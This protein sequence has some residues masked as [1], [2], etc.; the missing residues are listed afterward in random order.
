MKPVLNVVKR[1]HATLKK[2]YVDG[3]YAGEPFKTWGKTTLNLDVEVVLR[4]D[5]GVTVK[6][7][8]ATL[9]TSTPTPEEFNMAVSLA[10]TGGKGFKVVAKRWVVERTFAWL[11]NF[12]RLK[13]DYEERI[14]V[15]YGFRLICYFLPPVKA[16]QGFHPVPLSFQPAALCGERFLKI[17]QRPEMPVL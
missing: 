17:S 7:G 5:A 9:A 8:I 3:G 6:D 15:S 10:R 2:V 1:N 14:D 12:R 11:L 16:G 13:V 4:Q